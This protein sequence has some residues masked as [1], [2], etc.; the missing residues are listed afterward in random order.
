VQD[1]DGLVHEI[2]YSHERRKRGRDGKYRRTPAYASPTPPGTKALS[3]Q[4]IRFPARALC[5]HCDRLTD[6]DPEVLCVAA[7]LV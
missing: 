4:P 2:N 3:L 6:L 7:P 1:E 5:P